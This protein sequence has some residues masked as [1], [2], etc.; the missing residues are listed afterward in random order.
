MIRIKQKI[1][2]GIPR[3]VVDTK[4]NKSSNQSLDVDK[5][6]TSD[7]LVNILEDDYRNVNTFPKKIQ[8][9][10]ITNDVDLNDVKHANINEYLKMI[11]T[12][13]YEESYEKYVNCM[14]SQ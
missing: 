9:E 11:A 7:D 2:S 6:V 3:H 5:I 12:E 8:N 4:F 10:P 14:V 13:I 1:S